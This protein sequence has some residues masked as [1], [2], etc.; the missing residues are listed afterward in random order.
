MISCPKCSFLGCCVCVSLLGVMKGSLIDFQ[1]NILLCIEGWLSECFGASFRAR[2]I[3]LM[4]L[5][6]SC[7]PTGAGR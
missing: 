5:S 4:Y 1:Y 2:V 7:E 3:D 6:I